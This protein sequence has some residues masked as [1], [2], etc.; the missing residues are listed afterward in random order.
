MYVCS[1]CFNEH[2]G[3]V[4]GSG[5]R[6]GDCEL[7]GGLKGQWG[8]PADVYVKNLSRPIGEDNPKRYILD[9]LDVIAHGPDSTNELM[10]S[11]GVRMSRLT[12]TRTRDFIDGFRTALAD[13][14]DPYKKGQHDAFEF[15]IQQID[16]DLERKTS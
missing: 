2:P 1:D 12:A 5:I 15:M 13:S 8:R 4:E 10:M 9:Q 11:F 6:G 7:C 14:E 3:L 16:Q